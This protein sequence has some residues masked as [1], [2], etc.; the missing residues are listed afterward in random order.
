QHT[1]DEFLSLLG[2]GGVSTPASDSA[3]KYWALFD[4]PE[5]R[6]NV[7]I[8]QLSLT[9]EVPVSISSRLNL[10]HTTVSA[11]AQNVMISAH[12]HCQDP[13]FATYVGSDFSTPLGFLADPAPRTFRFAIH[14][15]F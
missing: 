10:G 2:P 12:C 3:V 4:D 13:D 8:R 9:Y 5:S 11:S 1:G 7:R 15:K 6:N 14:S